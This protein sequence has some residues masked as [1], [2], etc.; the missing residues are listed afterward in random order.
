VSRSLSIGFS[1]AKVALEPVTEALRA[2]L[3]RG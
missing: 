1:L 2:T 3:Q